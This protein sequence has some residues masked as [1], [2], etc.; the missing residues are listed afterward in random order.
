MRVQRG[1]KS[2]GASD[3]NRV[4]RTHSVGSSAA[5]AAIVVIVASAAVLQSAHSVGSSAGAT[6]AGR[7]THANE[8][9]SLQAQGAGGATGPGIGRGSIRA[10]TPGKPGADPWFTPAF[11]VHQAR[12]ECWCKPGDESVYT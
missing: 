4:G 11:A 3:A 7:Q 8:P 12:S 9:R 1:C 6:Q 5:I 2:R 10:Q